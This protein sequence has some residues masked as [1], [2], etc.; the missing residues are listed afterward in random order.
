MDREH[1]RKLLESAI[2]GDISV[3]EAV[4]E[5]ERLPFEDMGFAVVD[6]HRQIRSGFPEVVLAQFKTTEQTVAIV[7]AVIERSGRV[8]A[9]RCSNETGEALKKHYP[10]GD[11][12]S[13]SGTFAYPW[14]EHLDE[15]VGGK[16]VVVTAGTSDIPVAKE[17][18]RTA[19]LIGAEV[20]EIFDVGVAGVHRLLGKLDTIRSADAIVAVAG[21]E[22]ALPSVIGGLVASPVIAVPTSVGYGASMGGISAL[23]SMLNSCAPGVVVVNI[24]N[25]FGAGFVAAMIATKGDTR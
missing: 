16:V 11:F 19:R 12:D 13:V 15:P 9:T 8:L 22:G 3:D 6:H 20:E 21:M 18:A 4:S 17:A 14:G 2:R 7:G 10:K 23:L 1:L 5:L 24:D 25:G